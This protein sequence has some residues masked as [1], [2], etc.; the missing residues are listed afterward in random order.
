M[1]LHICGKIFYMIF[2]MTFGYGV[3]LKLNLVFIDMRA[4]F[5]PEILE[6]E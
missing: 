6:K 3:T 1:M 4:F 2:G 5:T